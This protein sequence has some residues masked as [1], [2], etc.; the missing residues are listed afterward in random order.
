MSHQNDQ[1]EQGSLD[2]LLADLATQVATLSAQVDKL[3]ASNTNL[4]DTNVSNV[5]SI[6]ADLQNKLAT[7]SSRDTDVSE[8]EALKSIVPVWPL[9]AKLL[10]ANEMFNFNQAVNQ[11]KQIIQ[12]AISQANQIHQNAITHSNQLHGESVNAAGVRLVMGN[13]LLANAIGQPAYFHENAPAQQD[14]PG[15]GSD[16]GP[17][18]QTVSTGESK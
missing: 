15:E 18:T 1:N 9:N 6:L 3:S 2:A 10:F 7:A 17:V 13:K 14:T 11:G 12:N 8:E 5:G 4:Q 16:Q